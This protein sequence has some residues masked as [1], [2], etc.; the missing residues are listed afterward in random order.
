MITLAK[1][2]KLVP[3]HGMRRGGVHSWAENHICVRHTAVE[4]TTRECLASQQPASDCATL[5]ILAQPTTLSA[6]RGKQCALGAQLTHGKQ[7]RMGP[8]GS[9]YLCLVP[10]KAVGAWPRG[11]GLGHSPHLLLEDAGG[12]GSARGEG[13]TRNVQR[14][15]WTLW[16]C[17]QAYRKQGH[18]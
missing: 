5:Q 2:P 11:T 12:Q 14:R 7:C 1:Y 15:P 18:P 3:S 13:R 16:G 17:A 10:G 8:I 9:T 4:C 6:R